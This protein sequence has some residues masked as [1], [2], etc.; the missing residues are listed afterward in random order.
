MT[1][2]YEKVINDILEGK[3]EQFEKS[4]MPTNKKFVKIV[5]R[6]VQELVEAEVK[7][8]QEPKQDETIII[9]KFYK[10]IPKGEAMAI[11]DEIIE[12]VEDI[13]FASRLIQ[14]FVN[15]RIPID[16]VERILNCDYV[17]KNKSYEI[18]AE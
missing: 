4:F 17:K 18:R 6:M 5:L 10:D 8:E 14:M 11:V 13:S 12:G 2:V 16:R 3:N 7:K 1:N 15:N 9:D